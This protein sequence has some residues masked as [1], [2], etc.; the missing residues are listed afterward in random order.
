MLNPSSI[1]TLLTTAALALGISGCALT[2]T[3]VAFEFQPVTM[4][5]TD[6]PGAKTLLHEIVAS[7][8][9]LDR[10]T[11]TPLRDGRVL[12]NKRNP[13]GEWTEGVW[14]TPQPLSEYVRAGFVHSA[15]QSGLR[16][17]PTGSKELRIDIVELRPIERTQ[18]F[19]STHLLSLTVDATLLDRQ[20]GRQLWRDQL[21]GVVPVEVPPTFSVGVHYAKALPLA[22]A[23]IAEQMFSSPKLTKV[24]AVE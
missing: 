14:A 17:D 3:D 10:F 24:L 20:S 16:L 5:G 2:R 21:V 1:K 6:H 7:D 13:R 22:I 18:L 15:V 19:R 23:S 9:R 8:R 11:N 12:V 4:N